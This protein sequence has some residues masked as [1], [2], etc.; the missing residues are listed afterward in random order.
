MMSSTENLPPQ[1]IARVAREIRKLASNPPD[2]VK[3]IPNEDDSIGEIH[4]ELRGPVG[5][6]YEGGFFRLKLVLSRDFPSAPP[7]G[8]FLTKIYHPNVATNG[9]ICVNTLKRDWTADLGIT[10]VLQVIRCLLIVP[11]PESSLNDE[12]GKFFMESYD[13]YAQRARLMTSVH[14]SSIHVEAVCKEGSNGDEVVEG[15]NSTNRGVASAGSAPNSATTVAAADAV[16][17]VAK[18]RRLVVSDAKQRA[19]DKQKVAKKK[20][21]KRL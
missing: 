16:P 15:D 3:Y 14:A 1:V 19:K 5:T 7:R 20:S 8:F 2:G 11:F 21:L 12:A 13:V 18:Q 10:H 4:A 9:D 6:P 17:A